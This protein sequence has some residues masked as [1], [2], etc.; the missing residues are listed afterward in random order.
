MITNPIIRLLRHAHH[1]SRS[2]RLGI[3]TICS[4][5]Q[6]TRVLRRLRNVLFPDGRAAEPLGEVVRTCRGP[7]DLEGDSRLSAC[8]SLGALMRYHR[9]AIGTL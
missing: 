7:Q 6:G 1:S 8:W 3:L 5:I 9:T 2:G 4:S